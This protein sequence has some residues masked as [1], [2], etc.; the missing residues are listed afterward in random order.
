[1]AV[2]QE[3]LGSNPKWSTWLE[4]GGGGGA[5][6]KEGECTPFRAEVRAGRQSTYLPYHLLSHSLL[7]PSSGCPS[8]CLLFYTLSRLCTH[9]FPPPLCA[10]PL[11]LGGHPPDFSVTLF[12]LQ[13]VHP[14]LLLPTYLSP[15][16]CT[17]HPLPPLFL[18]TPPTTT[19]VPA[20]STHYHH[21]SC[22]LHPLPPLFLHT[23]PTTTT[24]P[25]HST[26]YHH[27][28]CTLH[29]LPPLFLHT[30]PTTTTVPAHSTHYHHCSCTLH[31]L[32]PLFLH[33]PPTTT[34]VPAHSTHYHHCSCTL[35]P[36]PPLFLH[37]PPTT[38]TVPFLSCTLQP[39]LFPSYPLSP[40]SCWVL[41]QA[42]SD[43]QKQP[44][45]QLSYRVSYITL[46][47][48]HLHTAS[49]EQRHKF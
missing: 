33:T 42:A 20:H 45:N 26:H 2:E 5:E 6:I 18:H 21:C 29:P 1:M 34:T 37:T 31:P 12:A 8:S 22:T 11:P 27:C 48:L 43:P 4:F 7:F 14:P 40:D 41:I 47:P 23:P 46:F 3:V 19:T 44:L 35:H 28:S 24:V 17:L 9:L 38:T 25:A 32:P 39:P 13:D 10:H 15:S 49:P 30:P 36:L 16:S